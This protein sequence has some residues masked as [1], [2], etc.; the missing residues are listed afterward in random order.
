HSFEAW[1]KKATICT[2]DTV[3]GWM[4]CHRRPMYCFPALANAAF[5]FDEVHCYDRSLFGALLN[6]LKTVQAPTLLMSASFLQPQLDAIA[7]AIG[8]T[9]A[10]VS[11]PADLENLARYRFHEA[12]EPN[13][14][15]VEA[16]LQAEGK[17][18]WV[19][20]QVSTAVGVY[21]EA[22][23][24]RLN[25]KLYH[26]RYRYEDRVQ[27][28]REVVDAFKPEQQEPV[29]AIAT[30]VA[31]MSLDL[32]A[33]LLVSQIAPPAALIQRLG[34]L[35]R[36][37]CGRALDAHFYKD[38]KKFPYPQEERNRGLALI[39]DFSGEVNQTDLAQWL[40]RENCSLK[41]ETH[42]VLL[43][44]EWRTY[45]GMLRQSGVTITCLLERDRPRF[46]QHGRNH[47]NRY[48]VQ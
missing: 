22:Q 24:R 47:L 39:Q 48:A 11:G 17:V 10:I 46:G 35:N 4:Q 43:E 28:H 31:E 6:F 8:E 7:N 20:N 25:A 23:R 3:L 2:V 37:Y 16:E 29:L 12:D 38:P 14:E 44:G 34:R 42:S 13:W 21:E 27:H 33:T 40:K 41:P 32:S 45:P 18:L 15:R 26:S 19:C 9:P 30:Q 5:V 1:E 36:K